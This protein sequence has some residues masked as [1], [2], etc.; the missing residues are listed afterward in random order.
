MH[1]TDAESNI[2][3]S[4]CDFCGS[5]FDQTP[6]IEGHQGSLICTK[7]LTVAYTYVVL[8]EAGEEEHG[9]TCTMCLEDRDQRQWRSPVDIDGVHARACL[10]C[11]KQASTALERDPDLDWTR[12]TLD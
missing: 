11:I 10:R 9:H 3:E 2:L 12:P 6:M 7:C 1:R 4:L 8:H 5:P